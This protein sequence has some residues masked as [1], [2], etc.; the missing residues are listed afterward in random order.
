MLRVAT[1]LQINHV[2]YFDLFISKC[3]PNLATEFKKL[4]VNIFLLGYQTMVVFDAQ[5]WYNVYKI[6]SN[7]IYHSEIYP[8]QKQTI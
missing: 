6:V 5:L 7:C 3:C 4:L 8:F 2:V 1:N